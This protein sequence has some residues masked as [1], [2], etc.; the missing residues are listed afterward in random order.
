MK[1]R[2]FGTLLLAFLLIALW[3]AYYIIYPSLLLMK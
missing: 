2:L 3:Y 1:I